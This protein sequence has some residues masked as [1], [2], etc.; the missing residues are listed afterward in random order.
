MIGNSTT[1][2]AD[3]SA[4]DTA[5]ILVASCFIFLMIPGVGYYYGGIIQKKNMLS[6]LITTSLAIA[7]VSIEWFLWGYSLSF[8]QN[9]NPFIGD[10]DN[11]ALKQVTNKPHIN[12]PTIPENAFVLLQGMF[13]CITPCLAFGAAAE[14]TRIPAY[15]VF[16]FI[17]TTVVYNF[18]TYWCWAPHGWLHAEYGVLD[19]AGG[20]PVHVCSGFAAL[21]YAF[22]CGPR[23]AVNHKKNK[24][25]SITDVFLGTAF[26]WLGW[27]GFNGGSETAIN[28]RAINAVYVSNLSAS[29][30]G[31]TWMIL[32]MVAKRSRKMSLNG[33]CCGCVAGLVCITPA[34]GFVS[35]Y[36]ALVFGLVGGSVCFFVSELKHYLLDKYRY[37]DACDVFAV[38][39]CGGIIGCVITGVFAE[40]KIATMS[41]GSPIRGGW[42]DGHPA[43]MAYQLLSIV[44]V[45]AW[46]FILTYLILW[47]INK[48]PF[49][50]L[51]LDEWEQI[52]G[53][54]WVELGETAYGHDIPDYEKLKENRPI[55]TKVSSRESC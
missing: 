43:Q 31:I 30:G 36:Y 9:E 1:S 26:L 16:V 50:S 21:A 20:T 13:A 47:G 25:H 8:S 54:D 41:G 22:I 14:R 7:V 17:W 34:A 29:V 45:G 53:S 32:E 38:H 11:F 33:F 28:S 12:A 37:D 4:A 6:V 5:W 51:K 27:F 19:Y 24:P 48:V 52:A 15:L 42:V 39:G 18:C 44:V 23:K 2:E 35:P 49:L 55:K 40:N 46:S 10:L 3:I